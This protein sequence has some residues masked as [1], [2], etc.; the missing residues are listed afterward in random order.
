MIVSH[1]QKYNPKIDFLICKNLVYNMPFDKDEHVLKRCYEEEKGMTEWYEE[2][3]VKIKQ[4][5]KGHDICEFTN[6]D[7]QNLYCIIVGED[8]RLSDCKFKKIESV[9]DV[10]FIVEYIEKLNILEKNT[11]FKLMLLKNYCTGQNIP[12]IV[13]NKLCWK[14]FLS[15]FSVMIYP[16]SILWDKLLC[17]LDKYCFKHTIGDNVKAVQQIRKYAED[18]LRF[19]GATT[20]YMCGSL[21][22]GTGTEYSDAD[23]LAVFPNN[24][25]IYEAKIK[26]QAYW[27]DKIQIPYDML[28]TNESGLSATL[29]PAMKRTLVKIGGK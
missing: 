11:L 22:A 18:Y 23:I 1:K 21:A 8:I 27:A 9:V 26:S 6:I 17:K 29:Q 16:T 28:T 13:Y 14:I 24:V 7:I 3:I 12:L 4:Y 19:S 25:D 20:L 10:V 2:K 5:F 15:V